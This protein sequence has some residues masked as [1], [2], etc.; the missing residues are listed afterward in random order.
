MRQVA[1]G[2]PARQPTPSRSSTARARVS[3]NCQ[4]HASA[5]RV[6][7]GR[8]GQ[9]LSPTSPIGPLGRAGSFGGPG[10]GEPNDHTCYPSRPW[11]GWSGRRPT[12]STS[13]A[14]ARCFAHISSS[15]TCARSLD[16]RWSTDAVA[17][18]ACD[19]G[20]GFGRLTPVLAEFAGRVV[21]F[22]REAEPARHCTRPSAGSRLPSPSTTCRL[23]PADRASFDLAWCSRC[24]QHVPEPDVRAVI[25]EIRRIVKPAGHVLLCE[26]TD[27]S[28]EAGDRAR[29]HLGYTCGPS[30]RGLPG[31]AGAV[32]A[33]G[34]AS[35]GRSSPA[36][37]VPTSE[38][39]CCLPGRRPCQPPRLIDSRRAPQARVEGGCEDHGSAT[40]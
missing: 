26:E 20:C 14:H 35:R 17:R 18:A 29:A 34:D 3:F 1:G 40:V 25:D 7:I 31:M 30:R 38:P 2:G 16:V 33:G 15:G 8:G 21:G 12:S 6:E 32:D 37:R 13:M 19:V 9:N 22:E 27:A 24:L 23:L 28:L 11:N 39:T 36:I 10:L 4:Q 5:S